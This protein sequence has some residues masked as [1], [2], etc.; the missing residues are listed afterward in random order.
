MQSSLKSSDPP[1]RYAKLGFDFYGHGNA[2]DDMMLAGFLEVWPGSRPL[3]CKVSE[4]QRSILKLRFPEVRWIVEDERE[5]D[6]D[7]W[8][9]VGDT[10][11]QVLSG[12]FF[13]E[14]LEIELEKA[15]RKGAKIVMVGIGAESDAAREKSR[16]TELLAKVHLISTRDVATQELLVNSFG[17]E[18]GKIVCGEDLAHIY[19]QGVMADAPAFDDRPLELAVNYYTERMS[20]WESFSVLRWLGRQQS[21]ARTVAYLSNESRLMPGMEARHYAEVAWYTCW[22]GHRD[23]VAILSPNRWALRLDGMVS[24]FATI[25]TVLSSRYHCLVSAAWSGCR[26]FGLGRSSKIETLC[27]GMD[28]GYS[29]EKHMRNEVLDRGARLAKHVSRV[30]LNSKADRSREAVRLLLERLFADGELESSGGTFE[31]TQESAP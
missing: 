9:G 27:R 28:V 15:S 12:F 14:Y 8:L 7:L 11:L 19:L 31:K 23:A 13:L 1:R 2:G 5:P 24:H 30:V 10:P 3:F 22:G 18:P 29:V 17:V 26:I 16:F 4:L 25:Q 20:R 6:Y 21:A